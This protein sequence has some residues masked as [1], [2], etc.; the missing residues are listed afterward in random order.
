MINKK[1]SKPKIFRR[2]LLLILIILFY[3][4]FL[5]PIKIQKE[6]QINQWDNFSTFLKDLS[7][8]QK[9]RV[10]L[11][12]KLNHKNI[13]DLD[14]WTYSFKGKYSPKE[15][16]NIIIK[17]PKQNFLVYT[18]LEWRSIY[19]IDSDL[20][21][22]GYIS[23]GQY[24][25]YVSDSNFISQLNTNEWAYE[26]LNEKY[27]TRPLPSLEW[28]LYPDTYYLIKWKDVTTQLVKAQLDWFNN[29]IRKKY[30][31]EI[32]TKI[33]SPA[34]ELSF[35]Q[36][37]TLSSIVEKEERDNDNK[38]TVAWILLKRFQTKIRLDADI[39]LCYGYKIP[40]EKCTPAVIWS[41]I[42][43]E[44]NVF[45]TRRKIWLPPQPISNPSAETFASTLNYKKTDYLFYLHD[46]KWGIHYAV[47]LAWHNQNRYD[48]LGK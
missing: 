35:Y 4:I 34:P 32:E 26:F 37:L 24:I 39:T 31:S 41:R 15:F 11:Y 2:I 19:D 42:S 21:K 23:A 10:K 8:I 29:K 20:T 3:N 18:V 44:N 36:R 48:Y 46:N 7:S 9:T 17:W 47:D 28:F 22:K 43:D 6:I 12:A 40:Y 5:A 14:I 27:I 30:K 38:P 16:V 13:S 25:S 33:N 45:N 1:K